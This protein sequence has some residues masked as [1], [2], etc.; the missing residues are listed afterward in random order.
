MQGTGTAQIVL[1]HQ[2]LFY[3]NIIEYIWLGGEV[4][5]L[6]TA[7]PPCAGA[8]PA[9]ASKKKEEVIAGNVRVGNATKRLNR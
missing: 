9:R 5:T 4:V 3:K 6:G 8:I 2:A 7:N 1:L